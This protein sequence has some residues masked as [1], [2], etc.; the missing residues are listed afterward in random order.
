MSLYARLAGL[1]AV[2]VALAG[3]HWWAYLKGT[4]GE[5]AKWELQAAEDRAAALELQTMRR[6]AADKATEEAVHVARQA[7]VVARRDAAD[8][9]VAADQLRD[10][11]R[12]AAGR[13][14]DSTP[15]GGGDADQLAA[16]VAE[17]ASEY[18][19]VAAIADAAIVAGAACQRAYNGVRDALMGPTRGKAPEKLPP[20]PVD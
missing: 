1:L 2:L 13:A 10:E 8:A 15:A 7:V 9:R 20:G 6:R 17:C 12:A 16:V 11:A 14:R 3:S 4:K 5:R 19:Q 18:A